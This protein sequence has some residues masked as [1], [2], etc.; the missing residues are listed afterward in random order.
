MIRSFN[1]T[2]FLVLF[3]SFALQAQFSGRVLHVPPAGAVAGQPVTLEVIVDGSGQ[4]V[5]A[6]LFHRIAGQ[7]GYQEQDVVFV[8]STWQGTIP[9]HLVSEE[10]LEYAFVFNLSDGSSLGYPERD[11]LSSP[12]FINVAPAL[13]KPTPT[14]SPVRQTGPRLASQVLVLSPNEG[15]LVK[16]KDVL[17]AVSLF[18]VNGVD[19]NQVRFFVDDQ[20]VTAYAEITTDIA[21]YIAPELEV[22]LHT[23][24]IEIVNIY[25]YELEP[26]TWTFAVGGSGSQIAAAAAEFEY[27]GKIRSDFSLNQVSGTTLSVGETTTTLEGGWEWFKIR[28]DIKRSTQENLFAQSKNRLSFTVRSSDFVTIRMGDFTP[29]LSPYLVEGKRVRGVG[30]DFNLKWLRLQTVSGELERPIQGYLTDDKSYKITDITTD[31]TGLPLYI[32][33]RRGYTFARQYIAGHLGIN[34]FNRVHFGVFGQKAKDELGSVLPQLNSANFTV[35][36]WQN[37]ISVAGI[38]S[39]IYSFSNFETALQGVGS[40]ELA[41][42]NWGGEKPMDNIVGGFD[43]GFSFDDRR[44]VFESAWAMS[45]LNRNIWD[46]SMSIADLDT[47][48]DDSLDDYI[49]R[50]YDENGKVTS[51]GFSVEGL[52][53]PSQFEDVFVANIYMTP[54]IPIDIQAIQETPLAAVMNMPSSAYNM[55]I[56]AFYYG[57]TIEMKYSQVGPEFKSLANPYLSS[58]LREF[59]FSDRFRVFDNKLSLG[60]EYKSRNNKILRTVVDPYKQK[61]STTTMAFSPGAGMASFSGSFQNVQ[62]TNEKTTLDTLIYTSYT[63]KDSISFIDNREDTQTKNRFF[64]VNVPIIGN[65]R[66]FNF[67]LTYNSVDVEDQ[68]EAQRTPG[69]IQKAANSE[70]LSLITSAKFASPLQT[71]LTLSRYKVQIP[72]QSSV[73]VSENESRLTTVGGNAS[74]GLWGGK[75]KLSGGLSLLNATGISQFTFIGLNGG[76][77]LKPFGS[78]VLRASLSSKIKSTDEGIEVGTLAVKLSANYLF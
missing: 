12:K 51:S 73:T 21:T 4:V 66:R 69:H 71:T 24:R 23:A 2:F 10:G 17:L 76:G 31:S 38:D 44:L 14:R 55:K 32:L 65:G 9:G 7:S 26:T 49:G 64:S 40:Y 35:P 3:S 41:K 16:Q 6:R 50:S 54:L 68:L 70:A 45:M 77:E 78:L 1:Y 39:G 63:G 20:D 15:E 13:A 30:T 27:T 74:Y 72:L 33:D 19:P 46:G 60:F 8:R 5:E 47:A 58:N 61:T 36:D 37:S 75:A 43:F 22:G 53:D 29:V 25:S 28:A 42:Q 11:P 56:R 18:S 48:L 52:P 62:R 34:L 57:N 67:L 59:I